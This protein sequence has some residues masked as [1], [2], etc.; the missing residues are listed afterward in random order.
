MERG[1]PGVGQG[2]GGRAGGWQ[3]LAVIALL[4]VPASTAPAQPTAR[5]LAEARIHPG[6]SWTDLKT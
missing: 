2:L 6:I 4:V 3:L 1:F 5:A